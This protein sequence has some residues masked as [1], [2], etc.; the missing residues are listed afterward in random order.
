MLLFLNAGNTEDE[1]MLFAKLYAVTAIK[2]VEEVT[3]STE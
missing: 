2:N 1:A 3:S